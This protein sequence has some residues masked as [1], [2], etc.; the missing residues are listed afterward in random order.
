[1]LLRV[2]I[3]LAVSLHGVGHLLF[4]ANAWG[5]WKTS[6]AGHARLFATIGGQTAEGA[7]GIVMLIPVASFLAV[8]WG[9][10]AGQAWWR[11]LALSAAML[12]IALVLLCWGSLNTSSALFAVAFDAAVIAAVLWQARAVAAFGG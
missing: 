12:S 11:P 4:T 8:T 10:L 3:A 9:Y 6:E 7:A 2:I 1:M 5:Y